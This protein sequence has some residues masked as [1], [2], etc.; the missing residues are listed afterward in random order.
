MTRVFSRL[1]TKIA[2]KR[3]PIINVGNWFEHA[4]ALGLI[5]EEGMWMR[6]LDK[7]Q[8]PVLSLMNVKDCRLST[9]P[10]LKEQTEPE[11]DELL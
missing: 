5:D 8:E 11:D 1:E 10:K 6:E 9:S 7:Y 3:S 4:G 2:L